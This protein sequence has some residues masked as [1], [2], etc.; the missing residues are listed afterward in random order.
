MTT[1]LLENIA[2]FNFFFLINKHNNLN[3]P[4]IATHTVS[5]HAIEDY[6]IFCCRLNRL[7]SYRQNIN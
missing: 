7:V 3:W 4:L 5:D 6:L 2:I 1:T